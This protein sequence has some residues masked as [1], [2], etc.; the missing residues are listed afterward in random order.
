MSGF[1]LTRA[2]ELAV[3]NPKANSA[4]LKQLDEALTALDEAGITGMPSY[5][6]ASPYEW[7]SLDKI[8][9]NRPGPL[10]PN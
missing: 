5:G 3:V 2:D 6:I 10:E 1:D 8:R 4:Q 9:S 7:R